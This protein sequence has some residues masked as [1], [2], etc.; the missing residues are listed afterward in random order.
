MYIEMPNGIIIKDSIDKEQYKEEPFILTSLTKIKKELIIT[1]KIEEFREIILYF[2]YATEKP[3]ALTININEKITGDCNLDNTHGFLQDISVK[4][5]PNIF[6]KGKNTITITPQ[7]KNVSLFPIDESAT[8]KRSFFLNKEGEW[9]K[10]K[11]GEFIIWLELV[12][13]NP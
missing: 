8:F 12:Q 10:L 5:N 4:L 3:G 13:K 1:E 7:G 2:T 11:K 6:N 9:E